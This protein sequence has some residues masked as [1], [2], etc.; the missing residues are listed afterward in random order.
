MEYDAIVYG[1]DLSTLII[2]TLLAKRRKKVLLINSQKRVGDYSNSFHLR[3]FN[4]ED[5]D[6]TLVM[7]KEELTNI[8]KELE[9]DVKLTSSKTLFHIIANKKEYFI[10]TG[11][12]NF[13]ETIDSY[14]NNSAESVR[15]LFDLALECK[16][17]KEYLNKNKFDYKSIK[18]NY[19]N[20]VKVINRT[21]SEV[22]D[23][24][25]IPIQAQ[26]ILNTC[27]IYFSCTETV[28]S[29]V[30]YA[31]F[32]YELV[33]DNNQVPLMRYETI[34]S[35]LIKSFIKHNGT[36]MTDTKIDKILSV[37]KKINGVSINNTIY[38][39]N[40]LITSIC[41]DIIYNELLSKNEIPSSSLKQASKRSTGGK[42]FTLYLALNRSVEQLGIDSSKYFIYNSLD[43]DVEYKNMS[44]INNDSSVIT[45]PNVILENYSQPGTT[46]MIFNTLFF[47]DSFEDFIDL[48]NYNSSIETI[49]NNLI[50]SFEEATSK[51]IRDYIEE[52]K[53]FTPV[54]Y[55]LKYGDS[56]NSGYI[57]RAMDNSII[58][59]LSKERENYIKGLYICGKY[60]V[61]GSISSNIIKNSIQLGKNI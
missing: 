39:T 19:P 48:D 43:S 17:A 23:E 31:I 36:Y 22:F 3:R 40:K 42:K 21:V 50:T 33:S 8:F 2:S 15:K 16:E 57:L 51:R 30:D 44:N 26:E 35:E 54:D 18:E 9:L 6:D 38:Y 52:M 58:R 24:L 11:I 1:S 55:E 49:A 25:G 37:G 61:S 4:I 41:P 45:I 53:I 32:L 34:Y 20:F 14:V 60:G 28:L 56:N 59:D 27:W 7:S 5:I 29:F 12:D 13:I 10:T 46:I 47:G